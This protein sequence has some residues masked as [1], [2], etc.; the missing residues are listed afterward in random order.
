M[1]AS[2]AFSSMPQFGCLSSDTTN[3]AFICDG[4][5]KHIMYGGELE[6]VM[7]PERRKGMYR[8]RPC[9]REKWV[10]RQVLGSATG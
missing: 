5:R 7:M 8:P 4:S 10:S 6:Y 1:N 3:A 9:K 2:Y